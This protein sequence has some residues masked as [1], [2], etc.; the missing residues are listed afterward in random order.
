MQKVRRGR[1]R[2]LYVYL[3]GI[4][5]TA[6]GRLAIARRIAAAADAAGIPREDVYIDCLTLTVSAEQDAA[7]ETLRALALCKRELGVRTVLGV[8]NISFGLPCRG[9]MNTAFLTLAMQAGLDLAIMTP[10][11]PR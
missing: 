4:P 2:P 3:F 10:T 11:H 7:A 6:E 5:P 9:Y 8:S 1:R